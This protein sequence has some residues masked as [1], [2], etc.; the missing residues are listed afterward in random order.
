MVD[1]FF[2]CMN[3]FMFSLELIMLFLFVAPSTFETS[4]LKFCL[5]AS[6]SCCRS[7]YG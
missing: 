3:Q 6:V 2:T 4:D 5:N 7:F 1:I